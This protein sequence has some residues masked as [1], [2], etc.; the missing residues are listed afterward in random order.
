MSEQAWSS[1]RILSS[2]QREE[3]RKKDRQLK[4]AQRENIHKLGER[5]EKLESC[6]H[7]LLDRPSLDIR[8]DPVP[9]IR[10]PFS[11]SVATL[12]THGLSGD[13]GRAYYISKPA[14]KTQLVGVCSF[15]EQLALAASPETDLPSSLNYIL[16]TVHEVDP[17]E[18]CCD[19]ARNHDAIIRGVINGWASVLHGTFVCPIWRILSAIDNSLPVDHGT[20]TRLCMMRILHWMLLSFVQPEM[21]FDLPVWYRPR[22]C[23]LLFPHDVVS[24]YFVWYG[25]FSNTTRICC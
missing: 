2:A 3:K 11:N 13:D 17:L 14:I 4:R 20:P 6:L 16:G 5:I 23:Q 8:N 24:D 9:S 10:T 1:G 18:V 25:T 19:K 12:F 21:A 22:P 7:T 15:N